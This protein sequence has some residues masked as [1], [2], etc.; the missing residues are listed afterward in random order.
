MASA[1]AAQ[2]PHP[3]LC[4]HLPPNGELDDSDYLM[5]LM[6]VVTMFS[7]VMM[8]MMMMMTHLHVQSSASPAADFVTTAM[9]LR[10]H[11]SRSRSGAMDGGEGDLVRTSIKSLAA[12]SLQPAPLLTLIDY[13][14]E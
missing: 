3:L 12:A 9:V 8:M 10:P 7:M 5:L 11:N 2:G 13:H 6:T 1:I 4:T 14:R